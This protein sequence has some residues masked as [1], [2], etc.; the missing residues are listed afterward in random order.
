MNIQLLSTTMNI[1][2]FILIIFR[3]ITWRRLTSR[4]KPLYSWIAWLLCMCSST[5]ITCLILGHFR[6][7]EGAETIINAALCYSLFNNGG[8]IADL[9]KEK[10]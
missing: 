8:N 5:I 7:A 6:V 9:F 1:I 3:I 10:K 2:I 4:H